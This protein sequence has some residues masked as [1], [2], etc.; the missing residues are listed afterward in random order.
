MANVSKGYTFGATETVTNTKLHSLIDSA[1]VTGIVNADV[2]A[3]ANIDSTKLNLASAGYL[4]SGQATATITG[5][6]TF[7]GATVFGGNVTFAGQTIA[8]LGT[9]TTAI[10]TTA[11]INGGSIDGVTL[12][13]ASQVT[14][15]DMDCNGGTLDGVQVS[16]TTATG[17]LLVNNAS[18]AADGLGAQGTTGQYLTSAGTGANPTFTTPVMILK[19]KT[20]W[21]A[22]TNTGNIT[23]VPNKNY[24][25][26]FEAEVDT[27]SIWKASLRFNSDSSAHYMDMG[28]ANWTASTEI[29]LHPAADNIHGS[30]S[31]GMVAGSLRMFTILTD[32]M[33]V[34]GESSYISDASALTAYTV[35]GAWDNSTTVANFEL[36]FTVAG[37]GTIWLYELNES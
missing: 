26:Q 7:S 24:L 27:N 15:T 34:T 25:V 10:F 3:S 20:T 31:H 35:G 36:V 23:I 17:E 18:D 12:G 22:A 14:V 37:S 30:T 9:V 33:R 28:D 11:D 13:G 5:D 29:F 16:G 2:D 21:S 4:T 1:T 32:R 19:S 6:W 8:D